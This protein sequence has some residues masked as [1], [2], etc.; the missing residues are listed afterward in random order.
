MDGSRIWTKSFIAV[1][2]SNFFI[3]LSF[4][5]L[6]TALPL[7][8][9]DTLHG[10]QQQMGLVI[11]LWSVGTVLMRLFAGSWA[12]RFGKKRL[13][14]LSL[15]IFLIASVAY[16]GVSGIVFLL[17]LRIV[18]GASYGVGATSTSALASDIIP[19]SRKG[20]GIGYFSMFMSIAMVIGPAFG[21]YLIHSFDP[22]VL[23]ASSVV[24]AVLALLS[25][26]IVRQKGNVPAV[27]EAAKSK[28]RGRL[29]EKKAIPISLAAFVLSFSY[30]SLTSFI[31]SYTEELHQESAAGMFFVVF[32]VMIIISRPFVGKAFDKYGA[33]VLAYPGVILFAAGMFLL[34][35][36]GSGFMLLLS[37]AI[38][39]LGHGA[40][41]PCF[42]TLAIN[43]APSERQGTATSTYFLFFD[44]GY[45]VGSLVLSWVASAADY[46]G[47]FLAA[48]IFVLLSAVIYYFMHHRRMAMAQPANMQGQG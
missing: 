11:T 24:V 12:D 10:S 40:L 21:L 28:T 3:F 27:Q 39:G 18:H 41:L 25:A 33:H 35:Q 47:M 29:I 17:I 26:G 43:S 37:A 14:V 13:S 7:Y 4:Y 6:S 31:S 23:F 5:M 8:V 42:Q 19:N 38:M 45:G 9:K 44:L 2:M 15:F 48:S 30:S 22:S 46:R 32:A 34:S 16:F 1:S 36:E 20:E